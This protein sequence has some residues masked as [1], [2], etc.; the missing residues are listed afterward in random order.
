MIIG[1][2]LHCFGVRLENGRFLAPTYYKKPRSKFA[3]RE[4]T[5][6]LRNIGRRA[7]PNIGEES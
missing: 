7:T 5:C 1:A 6:E 2:E 3:W 4:R